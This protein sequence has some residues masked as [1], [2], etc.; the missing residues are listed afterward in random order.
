MNTTMLEDIPDED[1]KRLITS[2]LAKMD[3]E[4]QRKL[5]TVV[6][7]EVR[8]QRVG[9]SEGHARFCQAEFDPRDIPK[10]FAVSTIP[11]HVLIT[12]SGQIDVHGESLEAVAA[13]LLKADRSL[14]VPKRVL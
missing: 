2:S 10:R 11:I 3:L 5:V 6:T 9:Q 12:P 7:E 14:R 8:R 1:V 13:K 4:F